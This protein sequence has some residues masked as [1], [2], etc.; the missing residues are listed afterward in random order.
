MNHVGPKCWSSF[1]EE[2]HKENV[3]SNAYLYYIILY[4]YFFSTK[5]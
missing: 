2:S 3:E 4:Y 5:K 1:F